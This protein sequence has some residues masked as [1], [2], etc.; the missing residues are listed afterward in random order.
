MSKILLFFLNVFSTL[1][2][3]DGSALCHRDSNFNE[4][5]SHMI[6]TYFNEHLSQ[7]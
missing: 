4:V 3:V 6:K 7:T 2:I 5:D 1:S